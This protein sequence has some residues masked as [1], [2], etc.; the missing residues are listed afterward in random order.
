MGEI[1]FGEL[2]SDTIDMVADSEVMDEEV[3]DEESSSEGSSTSKAPGGELEDESDE[4]E[5]EGS[6]YLNRKAMAVSPLPLMSNKHDYHDY[7]Q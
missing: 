2:T 5:H 6:G 1:N 7:Q 3:T 4:S